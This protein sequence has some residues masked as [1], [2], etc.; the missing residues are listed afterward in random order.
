M[1]EIKDLVE[2]VFEKGYLMSLGVADEGGVWVADVIFIWE[3][4][5]IYWLSDPDVRHS[6][7]VLKNPQV[8]ATIT[9]S[10]GKG[11]DNIGLQIEGMV[12]KVEGDVMSVAIA[13]RLKRGKP[14]PKELG[15]I[16]EGD[17]WYRMKPTKIEL[18]YEPL[19][20]FEKREL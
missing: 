10:N 18:I 20:G 9:V 12:E 17:S 19:F 13:H 14:A 15:E 7:A 3:E 1:K 8:A 4:G 11:E 16:L 5:F 6:K 2:E